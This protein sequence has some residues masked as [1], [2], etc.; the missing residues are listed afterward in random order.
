MSSTSP[1]ISRSPDEEQLSGAYEK[2]EV[3]F[4][5]TEAPGTIIIDTK[6]ASFTSFRPT[7]GRFATASASAARASPG[8]AYRK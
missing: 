3:F 8:P 2:Q 1:V 6:A 7:T 5:T 4:R